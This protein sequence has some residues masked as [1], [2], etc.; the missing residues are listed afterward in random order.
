MTGI[1]NWISSSLENVHEEMNPEYKRQKQEF[2]DYL[3]L[4][5]VASIAAAILGALLTATGIGA[6]IGLPLLYLSANTYIVARNA[7]DIADNPKQYQ[8]YFGVN[9][10]LGQDQ[11]PKFDKEK[12]IA[13]LKEGTFLFDWAVEGLMNKE[14]S[15]NRRTEVSISP[16][17][18]NDDGSFS[19]IQ[20]TY[21]NGSTS[22]RKVYI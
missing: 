12:T 11:A 2:K 14:P 3:T 20:R 1:T 15:P 13:K 10:I 4:V 7:T 17:I 8:K 22:A 9:A 18:Q 21:N 5:K 19:Y 6:I 16:P